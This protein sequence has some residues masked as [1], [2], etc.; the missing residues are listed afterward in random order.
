MKLH[1]EATKL[2]G[3]SSANGWSCDHH[4]CL[5]APTLDV[6]WV[7]S[8]FVC[9]C[10]YLLQALWRWVRDL[11]QEGRSWWGEG[12]AA[13]S[14]G[15]SQGLRGPVWTLGCRRQDGEERRGP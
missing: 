9:P 6:C 14:L 7:E 13:G 10:I 3:C 11:S 2:S 4:S 12:Q 15:R 5:G 8:C 1:I